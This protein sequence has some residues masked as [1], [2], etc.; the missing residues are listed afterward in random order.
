M[1]TRTLDPSAIGAV[2]ED[3]LNI[4]LEFGPH[5][6]DSEAVLI[7]RHDVD[8]P[9]GFTLVSTTHG[10]VVSSVTGD[11]AVGRYPAI[12]TGI[13]FRS[14]NGVD[15]R[16]VKAGDVF[17]ALQKTTALTV[18]FEKPKGVVIM[19]RTIGEP[20]GLGMKASSAGL[21][22]AGINQGGCADRY[23]QIRPG[24]VM[25]VINGVS[26]AHI[27]VESLAPFLNAS[28]MLTVELA[29]SLD[30]TGQ[31]D[32]FGITLTRESSNQA[33]GFS[34]RPS[35][36][37]LLVS[38]VAKGSP[39]FNS[40]GVGCTIVS[41]NGIDVRHCDM[42]I[43]D[44]ALKNS[45]SIVLSVLSG[46]ANDVWLP[47]KAPQLRP[48]TSMDLDRE[49]SEDWGFVIRPCQEG[50]LITGLLQGCAAARYPSIVP[51]TTIRKIQGDAAADMDPRELS[52]RLQGCNRMHVEFGRQMLEE[53]VI[54][55]RKAGQ[56]WGLGLKP[57]GGGMS[58]EG[59]EKGSPANVGGVVA[60][61]QI[62]SINGTL[63]VAA[64]LTKL[65]DAM[66][67]RKKLTLV[68]TRY[69]Q[70]ANDGAGS[71]L[72]VDNDGVP[73]QPEKLTGFVMDAPGSKSAEAAE[74]PTMA[75]MS[76]NASRWLLGAGIVAGTEADAG[77]RWNAQ[78]ATGDQ[79][80]LF[81]L[82][83]EPNAAPLQTF[84]FGNDASTQE[85]CEG[86]NV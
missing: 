68:L 83:E 44:R 57:G 74:T 46:D 34:L 37:G 48:G 17:E 25:K 11:G 55:R 4:N 6:H 84:L 70:S 62:Q 10:L 42:A 54:L 58:V 56:S 12:Q 66:K 21:L 60:G 50:L 59:I 16:K 9:W 76:S 80:T 78:S 39:S 28:T 1:N 18:V 49:D 14:I 2:M 35:P 67:A 3:T 27:P 29:E 19:Q 32:G 64:N 5:R 15:T 81:N 61:D 24:T 72:P 52:E 7:S 45:V 63:A 31:M 30:Y 71:P 75:A 47:F 20:W 86:F 26:T 23:P 22:V 82:D 13:G 51:G 65:G 53:T 73:I 41:V 38:S 79:S 8:E 69:D 77:S 43:L 33:W 36:K 85:D 40:I